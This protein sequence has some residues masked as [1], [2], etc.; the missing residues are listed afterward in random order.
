MLRWPGTN[1]SDVN[2]RN[3]TDSRRTSAGFDLFDDELD[4]SRPNAALNASDFIIDIR[5]YDV[6]YHVRV[7]IDKGS[8]A[9][10]LSCRGFLTNHDQIS[11]SEN[12]I[13]WK[14]NTELPS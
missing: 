12:G 9:V 6:P 14:Q 5:E 11:E 10:Y 1:F 13:M 8:L 2:W 4:E 3:M 7:S